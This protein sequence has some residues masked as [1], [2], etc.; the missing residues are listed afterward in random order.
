MHPGS[1][2][3]RRGRRAVDSLKLGG[4]VTDAKTDE[5]VLNGFN[6]TDGIVP[7]RERPES[8]AGGTFDPDVQLR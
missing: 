4:I 3:S 1:M 6:Q 5:M 7:S 8:D 2:V